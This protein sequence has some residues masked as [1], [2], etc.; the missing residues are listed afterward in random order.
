MHQDNSVQILSLPTS[1][2]RNLPISL[3][4]LEGRSQS[5]DNFTTH[6]EIDFATNNLNYSLRK[7]SIK[8]KSPHRSS[9]TSYSVMLCK[10]KQ[11]KHVYNTEHLFPTC[12]KCHRIKMEESEE[13]VSTTTRRMQRRSW[14]LYSHSTSK[15]LSPP[16]SPSKNSCR[17]SRSKSPLKSQN[18]NP[19]DSSL[20]KTPVHKPE[21]NFPLTKLK[22]SMKK[23]RKRHPG[24]RQPGDNI[25]NN[26]FPPIPLTWRRPDRS[27]W[28][29]SAAHLLDMTTSFLKQIPKVI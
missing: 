14:P 17:K 21:E 4:Q 27:I 5:N 10:R 19:R 20:N 6:K 26:P 13:K 11:Q 7:C 25:S 3:S 28:E 29:D 24:N 23:P 2:A 1:Q 8:E 22:R 9:A 12:Q 18:L 16:I 15:K